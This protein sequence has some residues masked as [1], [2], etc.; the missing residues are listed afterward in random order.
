MITLNALCP[1][2]ANKIKMTLIFAPSKSLKSCII[3]TAN[4]FIVVWYQLCRATPVSRTV[5][6]KPP[7]IEIMRMQSLV[8]H[9]QS[10]RLMWEFTL[11][12]THSL[13]Q[14]SAAACNQLEICSKRFLNLQPLTLS[15]TN[16]SPCTLLSDKGA[17]LVSLAWSY[18][19]QSRALLTGLN[20]GEV[21]I[22]TQDGMDSRTTGVR[23]IDQW[24]G[25]QVGAVITFD[26][27]SKGKTVTK[28]TWSS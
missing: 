22:W 7:H 11:A 6:W 14:N 9:S 26:T 2:V 12:V 17:S 20:T 27:D 13:I 24:F 4:C 18:P 25:R 10:Q 8:L 23:T 3:P 15:H 16:V 5:R 21:I 19:R 28:L 1:K